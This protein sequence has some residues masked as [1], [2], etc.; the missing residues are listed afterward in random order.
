MGEAQPTPIFHENLQ[1]LRFVAKEYNQPTIQTQ[2][3]VET[4][5]APLSLGIPMW[6][7]SLHLDPI[8][9]KQLFLSQDERV[10][11]VT[12]DDEIHLK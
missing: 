8:N 3:S 7:R 1:G 9:E 2:V 4:A 10:T 5:K 6:H 12:T 11:D